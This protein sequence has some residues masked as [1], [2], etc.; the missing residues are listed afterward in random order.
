MVTCRRSIDV[1]G[2]KIFSDFYEFYKMKILQ[3]RGD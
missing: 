3:E 2:Y 1:G